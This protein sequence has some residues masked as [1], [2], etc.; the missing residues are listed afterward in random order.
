MKN[1]NF[2]FQ[3]TSTDRRSQDSN[4][5]HCLTSK[6]I[7]N[8]TFKDEWLVEGHVELKSTDIIYGI[9]PITT[10]NNRGYFKAFT[11][12]LKQ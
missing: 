12:A 10:E 4:G 1:V 3:T 5:V 11:N 7:I 6:G 9:M 8:V 2:Y